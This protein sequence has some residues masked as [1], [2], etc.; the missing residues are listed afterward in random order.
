MKKPKVAMGGFTLL[1][2]VLARGAGLLTVVDEKGLEA[3]KAVLNTFSKDQ[4]QLART[5][6]NVLTLIIVAFVVLKVLS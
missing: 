3:V 1:R 6:W 4:D 5:I 2:D